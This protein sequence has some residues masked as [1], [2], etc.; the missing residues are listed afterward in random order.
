MAREMRISP[1]TLSRS[2]RT[3]RFSS[4]LQSKLLIYLG[5][6]R[7][8]DP[9]GAAALEEAL[10]KTL[11]LVTELNMVIPDLHKRLVAALDPKGLVGQTAGE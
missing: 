7:L 2:L 9:S 5:G 11:Q 6:E 8:K 1:S 4:G 10:Q 3:G